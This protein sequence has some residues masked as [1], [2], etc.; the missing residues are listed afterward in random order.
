MQLL[1]D[2]HGVLLKFV[3]KFSVKELK[4][5]LHF[6]VD[7]NK[8]DD[9]IYF[10]LISNVVCKEFGLPLKKLID[11]GNNTALYRNVCYYMHRKFDKKYSQAKMER[12]YKRGRNCVRTGLQTID[13]IIAQPRIDKEAF[14]KINKIEY[15][16]TNLLEWHNQKESEQVTE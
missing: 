1:E 9:E 15:K 7:E 5:L 10:S 14:L 11:G 6:F 13:N 16:L 2:L 3:D 4:E 8:D 12:L